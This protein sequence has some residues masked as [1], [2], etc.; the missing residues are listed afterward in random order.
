MRFRCGDAHGSR[1][2]PAS[3][4]HARWRRP[5]RL[6]RR[7]ATRA[8]DASPIRRVFRRGVTSLDFAGYRRHK[9]EMRE[10][11]CWQAWTRCELAKP[12]GHFGSGEGGDKPDLARSVGVSRQL[13]S[14]IETGR[15]GDVQMRA[16]RRVVEG[17]GAT[18]TSR[19]RWQGEGLDRLM[20][21]AHAGLVESVVRRLAAAAGWVSVVEAS[22]AVGAERGSIDVFARP[23]FHSHG[24][25]RRS[26][27]GDSDS[28]ATIHAL[29]RKTRLGQGPRPRSWMVVPRVGSHLGCRRV[30]DRR[31]RRV[32]GARSHVPNRVPGTRR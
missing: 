32:E 3:V 5:S 16:L 28:Q 20:D 12:A 27:V 25:G 14:K 19:V 30:D 7:L 29:D 13:I 4:A 23:R 31:G 6:P 18:W 17:L 8:R 26:Q 24:L 2:L 21:A 10:S 22:F 15:S 11:A 9:P 1:S